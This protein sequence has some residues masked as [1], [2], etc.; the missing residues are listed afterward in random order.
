MQKN[1]AGYTDIIFATAKEVD[2]AVFRRVY[3]CAN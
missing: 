1:A 3:K 2:M